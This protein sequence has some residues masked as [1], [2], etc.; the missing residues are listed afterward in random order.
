MQ[1]VYFLL[2]KEAF[3]AV[4]ILDIPKFKRYKSVVIE[5][6]MLGPYSDGTRTFLD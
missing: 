1:K 6:E 4:N 2:S 3:A 5:H